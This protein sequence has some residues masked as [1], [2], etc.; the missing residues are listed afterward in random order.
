[1]SDATAPKVTGTEETGGEPPFDPNKYT[2]EQLVLLVTSER[3]HNI[4]KQSR[5]ELKELKE[6]QEKVKELH[7]LL[8]KINSLTDDVGKVKVDEELKK[9]LEAAKEAGIDIDIKDVGKEYDGRGRER[10][11][12]NIRMRID[13]LNVKNDMQIQAVTR[14]TNERYESYQLARSIIKPLDEDKKNK[15]RAIRGN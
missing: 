10:L 12:D 4:E 15:A 2:L 7:D 1:M 5:D 3:L 6:R 13:D 8:S 9:L 11:V 14:L